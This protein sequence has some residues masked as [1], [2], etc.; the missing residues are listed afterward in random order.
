MFIFLVGFV[1]IG[2]STIVE[3]NGP[4]SGPHALTVSF[5]YASLNTEI[6]S[7]AALAGGVGAGLIGAGSETGI[8]G[9]SS[10][11][12]LLMK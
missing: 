2:L 5:V 11:L 12:I 9:A 10:A 1:A 8:T 3:E 6:T 4:Q 7:A